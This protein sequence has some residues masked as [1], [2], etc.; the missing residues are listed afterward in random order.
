MVC[1]HVVDEELLLKFGKETNETKP[2]QSTL[3][4]IE[5]ISARTN[6]SGRHRTKSTAQNNKNPI[7]VQAQNSNQEEKDNKIF[8]N[9]SCKKKESE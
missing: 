7:L 2:K 9:Q 4:R 1:S 5:D 6:P 3:Q 8:C